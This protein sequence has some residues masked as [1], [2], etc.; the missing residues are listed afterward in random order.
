MSFEECIRNGD[1]IELKKLLQTNVNALNV[2][3]GDLLNTPLHTAARKGYFEAVRLLLD[4]GAEAT[5]KNKKGLYPSHIAATYGRLQCLKTLLE[6][7]PKLLNTLDKSGNSLLHIAASKDHFDIVQYLV[8]KN[9]DVKI[10]NKDGN[11][12][13]HNAAI[14]KREDILK[15]L[16]NLNET[17]INDSNNK[18][19][20]LLHIASSKGCLLMVQFLLYKGASAS[21]KNRNGKTAVQEAANNEVQNCFLYFNRYLSI[22][23]CLKCDDTVAAVLAKRRYENENT[24]LHIVSMFENNQKEIRQLVR[25]GSDV[26]ALNS[27]NQSPLHLAIIST[28][29]SNAEMLVCV[30]AN[31]N[32]RDKENGKTLLHLIAQHNIVKC[33]PLFLKS[34]VSL[35]QVDKNGETPLMYAAK[36]CSRD[37][38]LFLLKNNADPMIEDI[39]QNNVLHH[40][41]MNVIILDD[42]LKYCPRLI[43]NPDASG[44]TILM[45]AVADNNLKAISVLI[46]HGADRYKKNTSGKSAYALAI[47]SKNNDVILAIENSYKPV[48]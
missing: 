42:I 37:V 27:L 28:H 21:L 39:K 23:K 30:G 14:W 46:S 2:A 48:F 9:I 26:N 10:K 16:V 18:G 5:V 29:I 15:Y 24:T 44:N 6:K 43:D 47:N 8:S 13:C 1:L 33:L 31:V 40:A 11:Y 20:T 35:N 34:K 22:R 12:A 19:E 45:N 36:Y 4:A 25:S 32:E 7:E 38:L 41:N 17:P 3:S